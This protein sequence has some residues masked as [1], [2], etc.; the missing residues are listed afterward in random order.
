MKTKKPIILALFMVMIFMSTTISY[1]SFTD[2]SKSAA[3]STAASRLVNLG[4]MSSTSD[5]KFKP[6][7]YVTREQFAR[8][9]VAASGL[10]EL[11]GTMA[12]TSD[13]A[14]VSAASSSSG[15]INVVVSK[16]YLGAMAD[17]KFHPSGN[18]TYAQVCTV[19]VKMLGYTNTDVSGVWP[20]NYIEKAKS[21]GLTKGISLKSG[22]YVTKSNLALMLDK[23]LDTNIKKSNQSDADKTYISSIGLD[24]DDNY[25]VYSKPEVVTDYMLGHFKIGTVNLMGNQTF[26]KNTV[27][28]TVSPATTKIGESISW[29]QIKSNDVVYQVSD[30]RN[31]NKY[32]LVVDDKITGEITSI[33]PSTYNPKTL[34]IDGKSYEISSSMD[35]SKLNGSTG[36][37]NTGDTVTA[38]LGY[39]GKVVDVILDVDE[40]N[41]NYA[42]VL[43]NYTKVSTALEDY[44]KEAWYAKL[45]HTDGTTATY[46]LSG[47]QTGL[48]GALVKYNVVGTDD[49]EDLKIAA[50]EKVSELSDQEYTIDKDNRKIDS[51]YIAD[52]VKIFNLVYARSNSDSNAELLKWSDLPNGKIPEGKIKYL[53]KVG[54]FGDINIVYLDN[55]FDDDS[56]LGL[57]TKT[58]QSRSRMGSSTVYTLSVGGTDYESTGINGMEKGS[59]VKVRVRDDSIY[60]LDYLVNPSEESTKVDAI[61][62]KR[63]KINGRIYQFTDDAV[64]YLKDYAG[65]YEKKGT[66]DIDTSKTYGKVSVYIDDNGQSNKK[67][68]LVIISAN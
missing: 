68:N 4:I 34:Q 9:V 14:D 41:S 40:D 10:E 3:Y 61:D 26:I 57:V 1:A 38:L 19:L 8:T 12:G 15:Y 13:F 5:S 59:V 35:I 31:G 46:K 42:L 30:K 49:D 48:N 58:A 11:A 43:N 64:I 18:I 17:G 54:D 60:S 24:T 36:S 28:N 56:A 44:G 37:Y 55:I 20:A 33:L 67:V 52:N 29:T 32:I 66:Y 22:S 39:D 7:D 50:V 25:L 6:N 2:V 45:L 53:N 62:A 51:S 21:L 27:D 47:T 16:G 23:L 63:I 65:D